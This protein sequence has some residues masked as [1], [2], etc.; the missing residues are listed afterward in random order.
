MAQPSAL[1]DQNV[2]PVS[3]C[4]R[5]TG[6]ETGRVGPMVIEHCS[7]DR[8]GND[9]FCCQTLGLATRHG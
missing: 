9:I 3:Q 6:G 7:F 4:L 2:I 8:E 1:T 5:Q